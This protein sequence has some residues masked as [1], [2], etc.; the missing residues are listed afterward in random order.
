MSKGFA[1]S[2]STNLILALLGVAILIGSI[3]AGQY[4][5]ERFQGAAD[6]AYETF[7]TLGIEL[8]SLERQTQNLEA[9]INANFPEGAPSAQAR[10]QGLDEYTMQKM[11]QESQR[12]R[13]L[14]QERADAYREAYQH[15]Q[16]VLFDLNA[17]FW[18]TL[19]GFLLGT[20]LTVF[21]LFAWYFDIRIIKDRRNQSRGDEDTA[22]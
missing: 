1:T 14:I 3:V 11:V 21:G 18:E 20:L 5:V 9:Q 17:L 22:T 6:G 10:A 15:K 16:Q 12:L 2:R 13:N 7:I 8:R 19:L 4:R